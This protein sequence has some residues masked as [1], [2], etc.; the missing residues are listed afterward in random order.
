MAS[1]RARGPLRPDFGSAYWLTVT[2]TLLSVVAAVPTAEMVADPTL[3]GVTVAVVLDAP[4]EIVT[5]ETTEATPGV[6]L[7]RF[8]VSDSPPAI[9]SKPLLVLALMSGLS[10]AFATINAAGP[11]ETVV[12][13][14]GSCAGEKITGADGTKLIVAVLLWKLGALAVNVDV[15]ELPKP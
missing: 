7:L 2:A 15:P 6:V 4:P 12:K 8:T 11:A 13:K 14:N 10:C 1:R 5:C 9:C 3:F